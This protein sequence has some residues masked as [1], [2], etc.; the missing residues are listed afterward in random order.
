MKN[1]DKRKVEERKATP[2]SDGDTRPDQQPQE[3]WP[4]SNE[5]K[6]HVT[7]ERGADVNSLED[8][9]DGLGSK[10]RSNA[11]K[12]ANDTSAVPYSHDEE[13]E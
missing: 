8:Y 10:G 11:N 2:V 13:N 4:V 1:E 9:K 12:D 6:G 7:K 5:M 3:K